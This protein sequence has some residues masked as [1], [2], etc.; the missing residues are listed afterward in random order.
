[1]LYVSLCCSNSERLA[2][3]SSACLP[4]ASLSFSF[5]CDL[6][7]KCFLRSC[8]FPFQGWSRKPCWH[9][10]LKDSLTLEECNLVWSDVGVLDNTHPNIHA[11]PLLLFFLGEMLGLTQLVLD[12]PSV[13]MSGCAVQADLSLTGNPSL[14]GDFLGNKQ[15]MYLL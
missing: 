1:M 13:P 3:Y 4:G 2:F 10:W 9:Y 8:S 15:N 11:Y 14:R 12:V 7:P 6:Y 5:S